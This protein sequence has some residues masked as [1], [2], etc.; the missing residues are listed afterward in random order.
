MVLAK[1]E[2]LLRQ[3]QARLHTSGGLRLQIRLFSVEDGLVG[4]EEG[5]V[6]PSRGKV[7]LQLRR[8]AR[9]L[10]DRMER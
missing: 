5:V 1:E 4:G 7:V 6:L 10:Q 9:A 2:L 3:V 8:G